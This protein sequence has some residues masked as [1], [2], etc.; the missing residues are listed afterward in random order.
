MLLST[1]EW[2]V[3]QN[4]QKSWANSCMLFCPFPLRLL[5]PIL[6]YGKFLL[7]YCLVY[8]LEGNAV[9]LYFSSWHMSHLR[10]Q[11]KMFTTQA[12]VGFMKH[13]YV[14][15]P[16]G[17]S[18][19]TS[20]ALEE[21]FNPCGSHGSGEKWI[22]LN[23]TGSWTGTFM[24]NTSLLFVV[25]KNSKTFLIVNSFIFFISVTVVGIKIWK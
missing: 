13:W 8:N 22:G 23:G 6:P 11:M 7:A 20:P 3:G 1:A 9:I 24:H 16:S 10:L 2:W 5:T 15:C 25:E 19:G 14:A 4:N 18:Q 17:N 12:S 21:L